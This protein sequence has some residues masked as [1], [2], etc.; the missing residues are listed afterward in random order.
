[1]ND[2]L[3]SLTSLPQVFLVNNADTTAYAAVIEKEQQPKLNVYS[4]VQAPLLLAII[5][6][7]LA[8]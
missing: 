7:V 1:M 5:L 2:D 4:Q 8:H 6:L 3:S